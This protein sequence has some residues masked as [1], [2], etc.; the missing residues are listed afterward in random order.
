MYSQAYISGQ[1][2]AVN[3]DFRALPES[4]G[5]KLLSADFKDWYK[6][7]DQCGYNPKASERAAMD[8]NVSIMNN[9]N[10]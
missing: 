2:A 6:G 5:Y 1:N 8:R 10:G 3:G 7:Y 4:L 9:A